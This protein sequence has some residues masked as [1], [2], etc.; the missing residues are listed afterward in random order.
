MVCGQAHG[1]VITDHAKSDY[2]NELRD[3]GIHLTRHDRGTGLYCGQVDLGQSCPWTRG[4]ENQVARDLRKLDRYT[5]QRGRIRQ[6]SLL[7][8]GCSEQ[9]GGRN[10]W[11]ACQ[12]GEMCRTSF[13]IPLGRIKSCADCGGTHIDG[14]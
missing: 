5:S 7:V 4:Q 8:P 1:V 13:A 6:K 10:D 3:H 2:V 14:V 11:L 12:L 9:I